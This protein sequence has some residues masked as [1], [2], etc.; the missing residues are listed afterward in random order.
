MSLFPVKEQTK[1]VRFAF[2]SLTSGEADLSGYVDPGEVFA[3]SV[4]NVGDDL[5]PNMSRKLR[6][7]SL[8]TIQFKAGATQWT[9]ESFD[10]VSAKLLE[11]R[12]QTEDAKAHKE[13]AAEARTLD[14]SRFAV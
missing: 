10:E 7:K 13:L 8:I 1:F 3:W 9:L 5:P 4:W 14:R 2:V 12:G 11:A 6:G